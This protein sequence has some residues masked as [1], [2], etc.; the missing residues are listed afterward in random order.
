MDLDEKLAKGVLQRS[1]YK[2]D[3]QACVVVTGHESI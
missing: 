1:V 2:K 3:R